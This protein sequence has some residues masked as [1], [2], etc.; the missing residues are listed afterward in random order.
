MPEG[1]LR[2]SAWIAEPSLGAMASLRKNA[3][4][5]SRVFP[6]WYRLADEGL[7]ARN[8]AFSELQRAEVRA[9]GLEL[10][11]ES[12]AY[13]EAQVLRMI[14]DDHCADFHAR[15]LTRLALE[16]GAKGLLLNYGPVR[17][18]AR[19]AFQDFLLRLQGLCHSSGLKL[20]VLGAPAELRLALDAVLSYPMEHPRRGP[21]AGMDWIA[22]QLAE[23]KAV[24]AADAAVFGF[25]GLGFDATGTL[26][27]AAWDALVAKH[28]PAR[29]HLNSAELVLHLEG[30]QAWYCDS[31]A[32][33]RKL[34]IARQAGLGQ[35]ALWSLGMEDPR[36]WDMLEDFPV[37]FIA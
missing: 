24:A 16:D 25:P 26:D 2:L 21:L 1:A 4:K 23:A 30:R 32:A 33:L 14:L 36:L 17:A 29:R 37:P 19:G 12:D 27:F 3:S 18:S 28:G 6:L 11:A 10:W 8:T 5:L 35:A 34:W 31:I 9:S 15:G 13:D 20:G 22:T 7:A